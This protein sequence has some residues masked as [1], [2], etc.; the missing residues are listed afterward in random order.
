MKR[1]R[2][3]YDNLFDSSTITVSSEDTDWPKENLQDHRHTLFWQS[4]GVSDEWIKWDLGSAK[5]VKAFVLK[6]HNFTSGATVKIQANSSDSWTSPP[7]D[8]TLSIVSGAMQKMWDT[9]QSY[10]WW[11]LYMDDD[12]NSDGYLRVGRIFCGLWKSPSVNFNWRRPWSQ[13]FSATR[14]Q[15]S[16]G[17]IIAR[18]KANTRKEWRYRFGFLTL[19]DV[20]IFED[21]G[22]K[23]GLH[24][25]FFIVEDAD[26]ADNTLYYVWNMMERYDYEPQ[27]PLHTR[28]A[29][30]L[31]VREAV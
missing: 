1:I 6:Y 28:F 31:D 13:I 17:Q 2:F 26:D 16:G 11:R 21:I 12:S 25:P 9:P 3:L 4:T 30:N 20:A 27:D 10:R 8:V 22:D 23:C 5:D 19:S 15:A 29:L 14:R 24:K 7:L 18:K